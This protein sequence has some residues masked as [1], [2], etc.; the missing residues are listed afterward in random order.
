MG[1]NLATEFGSRKAGGIIRD[2]YSK[3]FLIRW[4]EG[5]GSG[6]KV[7]Q[8]PHFQDELMIF[9]FHPSPLSGR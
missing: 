4:V 1:V 2:L 7:E 5:E 3:D 6:L 9:Q 8:V